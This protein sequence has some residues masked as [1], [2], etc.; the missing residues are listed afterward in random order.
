[1]K[2][3]N[4]DIAINFLSNQEWNTIIEILEYYN[5]NEIS[6]ILISNLIDKINDNKI[7]INR[8]YGYEGEVKFVMIRMNKDKNELLV[9]FAK[10]NK[11]TVTKLINQLVE[12]V[13]N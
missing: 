13:I 7:V 2:N 11:V 10:K 8:K 12:Q 9:N 5:K 6:N 1:M 4:K 3:N